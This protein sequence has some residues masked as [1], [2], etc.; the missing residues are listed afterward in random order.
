[1]IPFVRPEHRLRAIAIAGACVLGLIAVL[2]G[3]SVFRAVFTIPNSL[4]VNMTPGDFLVS[5]YGI[6]A[7][8]IPVYFL[9][10]AII[11]GDKV[12]RLDRLFILNGFVLPFFTLAIGFSVI[13]DFLVLSRQWEILDRIGKT[14][15]SMI[16]VL[17]TVIE[18]FLILALAPLFFPK[19]KNKPN[20][21]KASGRG[22]FRS[23]LL[24][25]LEHHPL[26]ARAFKPPAPAEKPRVVTALV[27]APIPLMDADVELALAVAEQ[28]AARHDILAD[29]RFD[30]A[31]SEDDF[32]EDPEATGTFIVSLDSRDITAPAIQPMGITEVIPESDS[33]A[34]MESRTG[35]GEFE[36]MPEKSAAPSKPARRKKGAYKVPV[37]GILN[38]Y[39]DGQ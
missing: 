33:P 9:G 16:V 18:S 4:R 15:F 14:G 19:P 35:V 31:D 1:M 10:A 25:I 21:D 6:L 7:F 20:T 36:G 32:D 17:L 11:L 34:I 24:T 5:S 30:D 2:L 26:I 29:T 37:D 22:K 8:M 3:V 12:F 23:K 13:R 38:Q 27:A 28:D 39:P